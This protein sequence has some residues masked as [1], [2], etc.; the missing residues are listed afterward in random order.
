[1]TQRI[2]HKFLLVLAVSLV[3][4]FINLDLSIVNLALVPI[5]HMFHVSL[6]SL[7]WVISIYI[8][9]GS[10]SFLIAGRLSDIWGRRRAFILGVIFFLVGSL[11]AGSAPNMVSLVIGRALQGVGFGFGLSIMIVLYLLIF[12]DKKAVALSLATSI[13]GVTQVLGPTLGGVVLH[14]LSWRWVFLVNVPICV[15]ALILLLLYCPAFPG[16]KEKLDWSGF[17]LFALA[18]ICIMLALSGHHLVA[19]RYL[20]LL[21]IIGAV[22]FVWFLLLQKTKQNPL[23][24][25]SM[26][27][28]NAFSIAIAVRFWT[29]MG[30]FLQMFLLPL[31]LVSVYHFSIMHA[32]LRLLLLTGAFGLA[33][34][35]SPKVQCRIGPAVQ[36]RLGIVIQLIGLLFCTMIYWL[37]LSESINVGL[38]LCGVGYSFVINTAGLLCISSVPVHRSGAASGAYYSLTMFAGVVGTAISSWWL[39]KRALDFVAAIN[40]HLVTL[41]PMQQQAIAKLAQ[42]LAH[43]H[44][45]LAAL[46]AA[47]TNKIHALGLQ[48]F[49]HGFVIIMLVL[50]IASLLSLL[51]SLKLTY[52]PAEEIND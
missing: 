1:M 13:S 34:I 28:I 37:P 17:F 40:H 27:K 4:I 3:N 21:G 2:S 46:P 10:C 29:N 42:G 8:L 33:S 49:Q 16:K 36:F 14:W 24:D 20:L 45:A 44:Q 31:L 51:L 18:M 38:I 19:A 6:T 41:N 25:L 11:V 22:S 39:S 47:I 30:Y 48:L 15:F 32:G 50:G 12:S 43:K 23:M 52:Q 5:G 7:Q 35:L 9:A 26:F